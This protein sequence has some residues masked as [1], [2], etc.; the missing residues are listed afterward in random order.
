MWWKNIDLIF[1]NLRFK[2]WHM[3]NFDTFYKLMMSTSLNN[4]LQ[5]WKLSRHFERNDLDETQHC[6]SV[7][8]SSY[9]HWISFYVDFPC[10]LSRKIHLMSMIWECGRDLKIHDDVSSLDMKREVS[11]ARNGISLLIFTKIY[12]EAQLAKRLSS[13]EIV[14]F[15]GK[16]ASHFALRPLG[17]IWIYLFSLP[18]PVYGQLD[19]VF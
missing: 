4:S 10:F 14:W 17:K 5:K 1:L 9:T 16:T 18:T 13:L 6:S 11:E 3:H 12:L 7:I 15:L 19:W 2:W 8:P